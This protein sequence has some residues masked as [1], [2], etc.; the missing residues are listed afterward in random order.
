LGIKRDILG[1]GRTRTSLSEASEICELGVF[2]LPTLT[3]AITSSN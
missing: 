1:Y 2:S 3:G